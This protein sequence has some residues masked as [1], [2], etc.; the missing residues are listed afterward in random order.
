MPNISPPPDIPDLPDLPDLSGSLEPPD[1]FDGPED[2]DEPDGS[3]SDDESPGRSSKKARAR[4]ERLGTVRRP[5]VFIRVDP[6]LVVSDPTD[7]A[8]PRDSASTLAERA[9]DRLRRTKERS[10][11][12]RSRREEAAALAQK[13]ADGLA[14]DE[15]DA[16]A[17]GTPA[18]AREPGSETAQESEA[19]PTSE[20]EAD[21]TQPAEAPDEAARNTQ[22]ART[23]PEPPGGAAEPTEPRASDPDLNPRL[24]RYLRVQ[25]FLDEAEADTREERKL[26]AHR[27]R[28]VEKGR[29]E[30]LATE[31]AYPLDTT[32]TSPNAAGEKPRHAKGDPESAD[33]IPVK[34]SASSVADRSYTSMVATTLTISHK[35]AEIMVHTSEGLHEFFERTLALLETGSTSYRHA[36]AVVDN[37]WSVPDEAK[38][39]Y[40]DILLRFAETL[41]PPQFERK[42]KAVAATYLEDPIEARHREALERRALTINPAED[43][44]ADLNLHMDA[45]GAYG[46]YNRMSKLSWSIHRKDDE[47]TLLQTK[48]DV[49]AEMLLTGA[50]EAAGTP[51]ID[52]LNLREAEHHG[53]VFRETPEDLSPHIPG[54]VYT[55]N[56]W[57]LTPENADRLWRNGSLADQPHDIPEGVGVGKAGTGLGAGI[58]AKVAIHVPALTLLD[59]G[60]EPAYLEQYGPISMETALLLMGNAPG[61]TRILTDPDS[62]AT[63]SVGTKQ[64]KVPDAMRCWILFR[65]KTCRFPGCSMPGK[66]CDLDHSLDWALGG[67][68]KVTNVLTLCRKHHA[69][70]HNSGW[71]YTQDD[72]AVAT[73][74][75]PSGRTHPTDPANH[76]PVKTRGGTVIADVGLNNESES[77]LDL[78][79]TH[80][81][82]DTGTDMGGIEVA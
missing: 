76:I 3:S 66:F 46:I 20:R 41:T 67:E 57:E 32:D 9:A 30:A 60:S 52:Q 75:S 28:V 18:G 11:A 24:R 13:E 74:V 6:H 25:D 15:A 44:M 2:T 69:L 77:Q 48:A 8:V 45:A 17:A 34:W 19:V 38:P 43:G 49:A 35:A 72:N 42:A 73:W 80:D 21:P 33:A 62:G 56:G 29:R 70:K 14:R 27:L 47:R 7:D 50:T 79:S 71:N 55:E 54:I 10:A 26:I 1:G 37:G 36:Q 53:V 39:E 23:S 4:R 16:L 65:D 31:Y 81:E 51:T 12:E 64:Y 61:F 82:R 58:L 40:E 22:G 63:L 68:T 5:R 78:S 59:H